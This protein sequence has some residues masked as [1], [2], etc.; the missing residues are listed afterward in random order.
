MN[1]PHGIRP[2]DYI[3][4]NMGDQI[5]N[6]AVVG[7]TKSMVTILSRT[8]RTYR[9]PVLKVLCAC[10]V[11]AR[12]ASSLTPFPICIDSER[13]IQMGPFYRPFVLQETS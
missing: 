6:G 3:S 5:Q 7:V 13:D 8:C 10:P 11:D 1:Y 12:P 2:G 4:L 9:A